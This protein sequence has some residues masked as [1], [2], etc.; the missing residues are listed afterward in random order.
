MSR[1]KNESAVTLRSVVQPSDSR[2][3]RHIVDSS[4][5]FNARERD[6]A[7]ELLE[8]RL[9]RGETSGYYFIFADL[10]DVTVGYSCYGPIPGTAVSYDLYWIVVHNDYRGRGIGKQL[11][12]ASE[13]AIADSGGHRIYVETSSR[14]L[15]T[16]T[17]G[18]YEACGYTLEAVLADFYAPGD[19]KCVYVKVV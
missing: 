17:R 18:F 6:I 1:A 12:M 4:P 14:L 13:Q 3:I 8:E 16:P 15:Y 11:L 10:R 2:A 19:S 9:A 7:V 5:F